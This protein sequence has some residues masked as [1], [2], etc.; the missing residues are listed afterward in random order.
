MNTKLSIVTVCY[1][2]RE[3]L[4]K[5]IESVLR[6]RF[7][8]YEYIVIDGGSND[9]TIRVLEKYASKLDKV[10]TEPDEGI[11]YAMNKGIE[12]ACGDGIL[13]LN[14]GDVLEGDEI[15]S[16]SMEIPCAVPAVTTNLYGTTVDV[17]FSRKKL[18]LPTCHQAIIFKNDGTK[19]DTSYRVSS[20]LDYYFRTNTHREIAFHDS[21]N[22]HVFYDN[23]GVSHHNFLIRDLESAIII[24]KHLGRYPFLRFFLLSVGKALLKYSYV[25]IIGLMKSRSV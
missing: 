20:D 14:A 11:Y 13:F 18:Y 2:A 17:K 7:K 24:F 25:R 4:E 15:F 22:G 5:T 10:V 8:N 23:N 3:D 6:Q 19:Y 21:G 9:G 1:N 12:L 16:Q